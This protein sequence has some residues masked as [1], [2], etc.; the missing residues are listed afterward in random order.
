MRSIVLLIPAALAVACTTDNDAAD[1]A[2][3]HPGACSARS[4]GAVQTRTAFN[5]SES[6]RLVNEVVTDDAEMSVLDR[7]HTYDGDGLR[8]ET[9]T[10]DPE[11]NVVETVRYDHDDAGNVVHEEVTTAEGVLDRFHDLNDGQRTST[12]VED[13]E[14]NIVER[15]AYAYD[16][17]GRLERRT[18]DRAP[19]TCCPRPAPD[20]APDE[21][22]T[23]TYDD[24][25]NLLR[26]DHAPGDG[27]GRVDDAEYTVSYDYACWETSP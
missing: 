20:G 27:A 22:V 25:G 2:V 26:E 15:I 5:Y 14:G 11:G 24:A 18:H 13:A 4:V 1:D 12:R 7:F 21:T 23:F 8:T 16:A 17:D 6:G 3:L 9:R 19:D 10:E